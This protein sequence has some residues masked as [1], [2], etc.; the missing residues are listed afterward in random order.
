MM[1]THHRLVGLLAIVSLGIG[2]ELLPFV[3]ADIRL[4]GTV[5]DRTA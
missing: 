4:T 2:R 3:E 1:N 5:L